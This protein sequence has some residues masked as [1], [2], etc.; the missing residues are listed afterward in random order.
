MSKKTCIFVL[1]C[2]LIFIL[3]NLNI[4]G[5]GYMII[6]NPSVESESDVYYTGKI[7]LTK[8]DYKFVINYSSDQ[9]ALIEAC[10]EGVPIAKGDLE[11]NPESGYYV[12]ELNLNESTSE[13]NF[14]I[15]DSG[16]LNIY[17]YEIFKSKGHIVY[18]DVFYSI[19]FLLFSIFIYVIL[20]K[21]WTGVYSGK[22][23]IVILSLISITVFVS[24]P[25]FN[26]YIISGFDLMFH[27][28]RIEGIKDAFR[29]GQI[30]PTIYPN[31]NNGY[32]VLGTMYPSLFLVPS[33][34]LRYCG[35]SMVASYHF[36][37][38]LI[39][40]LTVAVAWISVRSFTKSDKTALLSVL[41]CAC[42]PLRL[43]SLYPSASIGEALGMTFMPLL[44]SGLY[45]VI[46]GDKRKWYYITIAFSAMIMSHILSC[47]IVSLAS[48]VVAL[49]SVKEIFNKNEKRYIQLVISV[50]VFIVLNSWYIIRFIT[51]YRYSLNTESILSNYYYKETII[52]TKLFMMSTY[53]MP[54]PQVE[55]GIL[56]GCLQ[57]P[58]VA[59]LICLFVMLLDV[60]IRDDVNNNRKKWVSICL[61]LIFGA[62]FIST[63]LF[64]WY[65]ASQFSL[66]NSFMGTVQFPHRF[67]DE[68]SP[69]IFLLGP[70]SIEALINRRQIS[71]FV[72]KA[73]V[74]ILCAIGALSIIL[75][76][77]VMDTY[78]VQPPYYT[79]YSG[80]YASY[81]LTEYLPKDTD[82]T[83][84]K[85]TEPHNFGSETL[86]FQKDGTKAIIECKSYDE[87]A[88]VLIPLLYYPGYS[89]VDENGQ[90]LSIGRCPDGRVQVFLPVKE[91]TQK[92]LIR[93]H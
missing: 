60:I 48:V 71:D 58:G 66:I 11:V 2:M 77:T 47:V 27:L 85:E 45:E 19:L 61:A 93:Y 3:L 37:V 41:L 9:D 14:R 21:Y 84:F 68:L 24:S 67:Y 5:K 38:F 35:V 65:K 28:S 78:N 50:L 26:E 55:E 32:G 59:G 86:N 53:N 83:V 69:L 92:I 36:L 90:E 23:L 39:N 10:V 4:S 91:E 20:L 88:Y 18:D 76:T 81:P 30:I 89:A 87:G 62:I 8:G 15:E 16:E 44:F 80:G 51:F 31:C 43:V 56:D 63:S 40:A 1:I 25:I 6:D 46:Y 54:A 49:L 29:D 7:S 74:P 22:K 34:L 72:D 13:F 33:A 73:G 17:N 64:P 52:P 57:G 79:V 70:S 82:T 75:C 42:N 12:M